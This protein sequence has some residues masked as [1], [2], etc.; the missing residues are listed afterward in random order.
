MAR[1]IPKKARLRLCRSPPWRPSRKAAKATKA[2]KG[3]R[4]QPTAQETRP[5]RLQDPKHARLRLCRSP[6]W[7]PS[8]KAAKATKAEKGSRRQPTAQETGNRRLQ[9]PDTHGRPMCCECRFSTKAAASGRRD[10]GTNS[11]SGRTDTDTHQKQELEDYA[12][13]RTTG[14]APLGDT[15]EAAGG[16]G[17]GVQRTTITRPCKC[18]SHKTTIDTI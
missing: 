3:S 16:R 4:R 8:R 14:V 17:A 12:C 18:S 6:P 10:N 7:R 2:E 5:T 9:D 1:L 11:S 13:M 15:G